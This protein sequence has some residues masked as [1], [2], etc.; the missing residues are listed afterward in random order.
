MSKTNLENF[1]KLISD[2]ESSWLEDAKEREQNRAWSD[3]SIKIAIRMLR[4]IRRQKAI[5]GMTQKKLAEKMGVTPQYINK[6]VKG[7]ENLTLETISKIE[8]VLGI[9]LMEVPGF[10]KQNSIT[11]EIE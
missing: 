6:V 5:N 11:L 2:E 3:K 9:E 10:F 7:K 1:K 8:Q 4:E